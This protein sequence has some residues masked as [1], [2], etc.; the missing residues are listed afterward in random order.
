MYVIWKF[1]SGVWV[2]TWR[3]LNFIRICVLNMV[4]LLIVFVGVGI[5]FQLQ[6]KPV[7]PYNGALLLDLSGT[8][9]DTP[10]VNNRL[11][12]LSK[13]LF[14]SSNNQLQQNS[15][16]DVVDIVRQAKQDA[17][18]T[19]MVLSLNNFIGADQPSLQY[20]GKALQEFRDSGKPI[21]AVGD[22]YSQA[23]Y[24]LASFANKIYLAPQ[25]M[26]ALNGIA[27][28]G[29]YY[30]SLLDNLK[31]STHIFRVGQYK[32]AVE[33]FIRDDM[34]PEARQSDSRWLN[35]LWGNYLATV[36]ANRKISTDQLFPSSAEQIRL[37]KVSGGNAALY[38]KQ[39]NIVDDLA[40]HADA[41]KILT[42]QFGWSKRQKSFNNI[43]MYD[44]SL[45]S[46]AS[47][48]NKIAVV[49][50]NGAI[51]DGAQTTEVAAADTIASDLRAARLDPAVK[52]LVLRVNSPG[53]S[54]TA[55]ELIRSELQAL[56]N[57]HKPVV[58]SMG[59]LA[60]S[61]GY[62]VSTPANYII[63][64]PSTLTGSIGIFGVITTFENTL[65]SVGVHTDG[66]TTSPLAG[67]SATQPLT[68]EFKQVMQIY[69]ESGYQQFI[70]LV[71]KARG[72]TLEQTDSIAQGHVWI[73]N[74]A[75]KNGLV[76]KLGDFD[77]A[78]EKAAGLAKLQKYQLEWFT[79]QPGLLD[80]LLGQ[81][82]VSVLSSLPSSVQSGASVIWRQL[83]SA[84]QQPALSALLTDPQHRY[85]LC[86]ACSVIK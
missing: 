2:G 43:S 60:A 78:I 38:A 59:G 1:L 56:R 41:E 3:L 68:D 75:M 13:E 71:A 34:S 51:V 11:G 22:S 79:E 46:P 37:L 69:V 24:Y 39:N 73:G 7:V 26:V 82:S 65:A 49:F 85:A 45:K 64:S 33:P 32:S 6:H 72:K 83:I 61:G 5:Y 21:Y 53:G 20:I 31:I 44:Y 42:E 10:S 81:M 27:T 54:V 58:V 19:G 48:S 74:D 63:A 25:G 70:E 14:G 77:D 12:M 18:I 23:Q 35:G 50:V 67:N 40:S 86:L 15:L 52:A 36:A 55:S 57:A 62:W 30:K 84:A 8:V 47:S 28:Q 17:N 9:V 16:F 4:F 76:D 29:L 66:V 80:M